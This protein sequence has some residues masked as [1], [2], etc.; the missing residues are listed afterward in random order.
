M[1]EF[2]IMLPMLL[3]I[4]FGLLEFG[5]IIF[6]YTAVTMSSRE[7]AR[8]GTSIGGNGSGT[9][10][11]LDCPGIRTAAKRVSSLAGVTDGQITVEYYDEST[12]VGECDS[13]T[14]SVVPGEGD[15]LMKVSIVGT[16]TPLAVALVDLPSFAI[17]S[18]S[19]RTIIKS[20][21]LVD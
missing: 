13:I 15:G 5:R 19:Q 14:A 1:V 17:S 7:A 3:L 11:Y 12:K 6:I 8:Y 16:Y 4:M 2:A 20:I 21:I 18:V 9:A 10:R